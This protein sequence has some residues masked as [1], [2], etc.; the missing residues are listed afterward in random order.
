MV[1][2]S[3]ELSEKPHI[4]IATPGRL[5]DH[6]ES[7]TNFSLSKI[8]ML[9]SNDPLFYVFCVLYSQV[10]SHFLLGTGRS[11]PFARGQLRRSAPGNI[12]R[13]AQEETNTPV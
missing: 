3:I 4:V 7:G 10:K 1:Q 5:A 6:I 12:Q 11:G 13:A 8:Q 2:Q 9:V